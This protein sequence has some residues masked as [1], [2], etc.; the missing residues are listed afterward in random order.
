[1]KIEKHDWESLKTIHRLGDLSF[2]PLEEGEDE[3]EKHL[4]ESFNKDWTRWTIFSVM[5]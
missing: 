2:F 5:C 3:G 1:M 4:T